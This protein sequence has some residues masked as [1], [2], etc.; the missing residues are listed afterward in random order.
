MNCLDEKFDKLKCM[1]EINSKIIMLDENH[2]YINESYKMDEIFGWNFHLV[3]CMDES[4]FKIV[5]TNGN[6]LTHIIFMSNFIHK[7]GVKG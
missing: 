7:K 2:M 3:G 5:M 1:D 4:N 6:Y